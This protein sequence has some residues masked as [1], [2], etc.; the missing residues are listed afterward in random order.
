MAWQ[1]L[2]APVTPA[3]AALG[4]IRSDIPARTG[5]DRSTPV[6][7]GIH[8]SN[9][10][11]LP[12]LIS[13]RPPFAVVSTGTWVVA[14]AVGGAA[15]SLDPA[16][17]T[18]INVNA[19]GA[20]VPSARFM[21]GREYDAL[22]AG[23]GGGWSAADLESVLGRQIMLLP[24]VQRGVWSVSPFRIALDRC[25]RAVGGGARRRGGLLPGADD[26]DLPR[27]YRRGRRDDRRGPVGQERALCRH[28]A[29]RDRTPGAAAARPGRNQ[30]RRSAPRREDRP[31]AR[32]PR[33]SRLDGWMRRGRDTRPSG[34]N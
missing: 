6:F 30:H 4:P 8:D 18:L 28:A 1:N 32:W 17:D 13:R 22:T 16:R 21:G 2:F 20:P 7:C 33:T 11:L 3:A 12:H 9:A 5:L 26:G 24:S 10:S 14:M 23:D 29:S 15:V 27:S 34:A 25:R 31:P 19:M